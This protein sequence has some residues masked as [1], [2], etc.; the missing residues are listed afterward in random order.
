M[1]LTA[2]VETLFEVTGSAKYSTRWRVLVDRTE[3]DYEP[4]ALEAVEFARV[5]RDARSLLGRR[6]A[7]VAA[8]RV[9]ELAEMAASTAAAHHPRRAPKEAGRIGL[10]GLPERRRSV[11]ASLRPRLLLGPDAPRGQLLTVLVVGCPT[12][13]KTSAWRGTSSASIPLLRCFV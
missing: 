6:V 4:G 12:V 11:A 1:D 5:L 2:A 10:I 3:M 13:G 9:F 7:V 8:G